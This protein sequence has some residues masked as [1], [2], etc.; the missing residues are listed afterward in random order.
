[1]PVPEALERTLGM[2]AEKCIDRSTSN[3]GNRSLLWPVKRGGTVTRESREQGCPLTF[4]FCGSQGGV[5]LKRRL[6]IGQRLT[7]GS[8]LRPA[9][10]RYS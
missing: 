6:A 10:D 8:R 2:V 9:S 4:S 5:I 1:M 7:S 3:E